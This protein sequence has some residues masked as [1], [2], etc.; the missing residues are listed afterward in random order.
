[1]DM[2]LRG[3]T[4][5]DGTGGAPYT[6]D[7]GMRDGRIVEIGRIAARGEAEIDADG[8]IVT[9]GFVDIHTH[10]DGQAC[11]DP[12]LTPSCYHGV[13]TAVMGNCGVGFAPLRPGEQ[14]RL[15]ALM[16]GVEEIPGSA[17]S[18]GVPWNW[19]SF[20]DY[21]DAL[22]AMPRAVNIA[23]QLPHDPLRLYVMGD[24]A[25]AG[26]TAT[27]D[28][29]AA[30]RA[31][32][33]E[34]MRAGA[35]GVSTGRTDI[36]KT[37]AGRDTPARNAGR[38]ELLGLAC[39]LSDA[40]RGVL[41]AVSDFRLDEGDAAFAPEFDLIDAMAEAC[42]RPVS[43]SLNQ[44]DMA[45]QQWRR[46][47][48]RVEAAA[49]RGLAMH[50]QVAARGIG[51]FFGLETTLNP[52]MAYPAYR[53]IM[54]KSL[55]VR[56]ATLRDPAFRARLFADP[57]ER[58]SGPGSTVPPLADAVL[59][60]LE[61]FA[62]RMFR[63]GDPPD[64]EP[65]MESSLYYEARNRDVPVIDA[66][67]D[68]MLE[69]DG[70]QLVYFPIYNY[71]RFDLEDLRGM[72]T[73]PRALFGLSDGGAHVGTVCDASFP[74]FLLTHWARDRTRGE[75]LPLEWLVEGQTRRNARH[76]GFTDRGVLAPGMKADIN[77][78]DFA[79]LRLDPPRMT[80]DLPAGGKRL[81]QTAQGYI[82]TLVNGQPI[83]QRSAPTGAMPGR[84]LRGS[85]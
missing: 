4:I 65:P 53:E 14:D 48:Q 73:H 49:A 36:H 38:D 6:A 54:D 52:L 34:A 39:G 77:V 46:I 72:M 81:M 82:A 28:E 74:S 68:V 70:R 55:G 15:I 31:L 17:L 26:A 44:R 45:P 13:T 9:P 12:L 25:E 27:E 63:L 47:L 62:L 57:P 30:M 19:E 8:A 80:R 35:V 7:I 10:Y 59:E 60:R 43:L 78:I 64:Y 83:L 51:V 2:I 76:M 32:V 11:W 18:E 58:L 84:L 67:Y 71:S 29:I 56:V 3:G 24:R 41:Q 16:E 50:V 20:A 5:Y 33:C 37:T 66:I 1:M 61:F 23:A 85:G 79:A 69:D 40:G 21:L 75:R 22:D 42:G